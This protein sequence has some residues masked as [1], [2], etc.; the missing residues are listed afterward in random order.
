MNDNNFGEQ[1]LA[2]GVGTAANMVLPGLGSVLS[3]V[4]GHF[5]QQKAQRDQ[6]ATQQ[7]TLREADNP[8]GYGLGGTL[9]GSID[10]SKYLG[11][12]HAK[13]GIATDH[14]GLPNDTKQLELEGQETRLQNGKDVYI[15]SDQ[16][17]I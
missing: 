16:L 1:L 9:K 14:K 10:F 5:Q 6:F 15:F 13:G 12:K 7:R 8:Y 3:G 4:Y 17:T 2:Q 11:R